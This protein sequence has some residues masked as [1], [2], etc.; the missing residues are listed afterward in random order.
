M[1]MF[2]KARLHEAFFSLK[3]VQDRPTSTVTTEF[4]ESDW[5]D[6]EILSEIEGGENS[7]RTSVNSVSE[8]VSLQWAWR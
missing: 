1:E 5:D 4:M 7:P 6:D 8:T 3:G 2:E